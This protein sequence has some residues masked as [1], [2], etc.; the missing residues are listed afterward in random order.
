M[1][2]RIRALGRTA[3][4][5][6]VWAVIPVVLV[7]LFKLDA[8]QLAMLFS[9]LL[10]A[11]GLYMVYSLF[12]G[13]LKWEQACASSAER[14]DRLNKELNDSAAARANQLKDTNPV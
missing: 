7:G 9:I 4:L 1:D 6:A 11:G 10:A 13:Q 8:E 3:G 14:I 12:L 5:V 2:I